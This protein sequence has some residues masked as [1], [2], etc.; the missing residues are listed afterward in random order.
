MTTISA[1]TVG[2]LVWKLLGGE[3]DKTFTAGPLNLFRGQVTDPPVNADRTVKNYAVLYESPGQHDSS[4]VGS[5]R[6]RFTGTFQVTCVG[7]DSESCLLGVDWV[8]TR[9][10]GGLVEVPGRRHKRRIVED[11]SNRVRS[12]IPDEDVTPV[13]FFVPLLFTLTT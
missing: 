1:L 8:T 6:D 9:L 7:R 13:R 2:N 11:P 10:A 4:R 12:V 3:P 5:S